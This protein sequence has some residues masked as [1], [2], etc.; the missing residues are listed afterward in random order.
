MIQTQ[1][2]RLLP[3]YPH[4]TTRVELLNDATS[5]VTAE[6]LDHALTHFVAEGLIVITPDLR[7]PMFDV[8]RT[9]GPNAA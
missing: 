5:N 9:L 6:D 7:N 3:P 8:I 1:V 2:L 4:E